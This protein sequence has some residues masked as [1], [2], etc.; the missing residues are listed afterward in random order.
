[1]NPKGVVHQEE[2]SIASVLCAKRYGGKL[3]K[4]FGSTV[5]L[6]N[7]R[8]CGRVEDI[9]WVTKATTFSRFKTPFLAYGNES[10]LGY[11]YSDLCLI[12]SV[13]KYEKRATI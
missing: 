2:Y 3:V 1:M 13:G 4:P 12:V 6:R 8:N 11:F 5:D 7:Y 9:H 10:S